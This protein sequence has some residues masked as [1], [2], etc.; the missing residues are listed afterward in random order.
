VKYTSSHEWIRLDGSIAT[1]GIT[2]YAQK[3]LGEIVYIDLP[4]VGRE[5]REGEEICVL[6]STKA[7]ADVYAPLSGKVVAVNEE[8][9]KAT[10]QINCAA[11]SAGWL[12]QMEIDDLKDLEKLLSREA[13]ERLIG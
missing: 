4:K 2:H 9:R 7:A 1:V 3:E 10:S 6:E 13:Y 11:E 5:I 8:V 12:F